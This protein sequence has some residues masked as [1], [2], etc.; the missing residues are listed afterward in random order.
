MVDTRS[1]SVF[2]AEWSRARGPEKAPRDIP[3]RLAWRASAV[4]AG[5]HKSRHAGA[6]GLFRD[7]ANLLASP[8]PRR[9]DLGASVR[10]RNSSWEPSAGIRMGTVLSRTS[11][12]FVFRQRR[13]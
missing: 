10:E 7:H 13:L 8:D 2:A 5:V 3:Y 9:I 4:R 11:A 1:L 6:G 12:A